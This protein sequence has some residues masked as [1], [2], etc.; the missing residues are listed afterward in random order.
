[1]KP[2]SI[3]L[4]FAGLALTT[5]GACGCAGRPADLDHPT[6]QPPKAETPQPTD[7]SS[8]LSPLPT[9]PPPAS[10][11]PRATAA[12]SQQPPVDV[13]PGTL[14]PIA[15]ARTD[16]AGRLRV[17]AERI[18]LV[19]AA[20]VDQDAE[21]V[22]CPAAARLIDSAEGALFEM[23]YLTFSAKG[24]IHHYLVTPDLVVYCDE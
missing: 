13:D 11:S 12:E 24:K 16:L 3:F 5:A 1:M 2:K 18:E 4:V 20:R 17:D 23:Q 10:A 6:S 14:N 22:E 21:Q 9:V 19:Q 8:P 7:A 15:R